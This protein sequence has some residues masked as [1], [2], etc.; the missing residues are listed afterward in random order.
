MGPG[1]ILA[2][3]PQDPEARL[4]AP[5]PRPS[6]PS[7]MRV[8]IIDSPE[9]THP[10]AKRIRK[11][12]PDI[13]I[14]DYVSPSVWAWRPGPRAQDAR[15]CGS[16]AGAAAVRAG[17]APAPRRPAVHLRRP[18]ADRAPFTGS[19]RSIT[20]PLAERLALRQMHRCS[21][22]CRA[23]ARSEVSRLMQPF[24]EALAVLHRAR[25]EIRGHHSR[26]VVG[27]R[28]DRTASAGVAAAAASCRRRGG[29]VSRLQAG[30]RRHLRRRAR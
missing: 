2:R 19:P 14:I 15:L 16:C 26:R 10:I 24:G 5:S 29:Q 27:A 6:P 22:C 18:S 1:A 13:P 28:A 21:S 20:A 4:S 23:A 3:L 30:A 11:R 9:F 12:R 25:Q 8:V 7:P 17:G